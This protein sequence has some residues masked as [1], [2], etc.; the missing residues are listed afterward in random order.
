[1]VEFN[2]RVGVTNQGAGR[3]LN[4]FHIKLTTWNVK[5]L[6]LVLYME[7]EPQLQMVAP[8]FIM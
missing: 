2:L 3:K 4:L 7:R 1:M 5:H 6:W 8:N